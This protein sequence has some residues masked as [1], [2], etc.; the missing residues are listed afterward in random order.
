MLTSGW[1][2]AGEVRVIGRLRSETPQALEA[3]MRRGSLSLAGILIVGV[4]GCDTPPQG[5]DPALST[6]TPLVSIELGQ[7]QTFEIYETLTGEFGYSQAGKYGV[8]PV[9][10]PESVWKDGDPLKIFQA[11]APGKEVPATLMAA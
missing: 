11:V 10:V 8:T 5:R 4:A 3:V 9:Q 6:S 2:S 7:G 1:P